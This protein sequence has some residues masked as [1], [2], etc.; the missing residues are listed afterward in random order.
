V[1]ERRNQSVVSMARCML[2][3]K[4]LPGYFW[5]E[6]VT[7]AVHILN[8]APT[9]GL[10]GKTPFEAWHGEK[11]PVHYFKTFGC[12]GNVKNTRPG[13]Q[14]LEDRSCPMIFIGYEHGSKAYHFY[15]PNTECVVVSRDAVFDEGGAWKWPEQHG[16]DASPQDSNTF[17]IEFTEEYQPTSP[18]T[19]H[20]STTP[21]TSS[22]ASVPMSGE[23]AAPGTSDK[24][25]SPLSEH[26]LDLDNDHDDDAPLRFR[27]I[28]S[29]IPAGSTTPRSVPR[30]LDNQLH[31]TSAEEPTTF[32]AAEREPCWKAAMTEEM[33]SITDNATW[34]LAD[35]SPGFRAI[36]LK[37]VYKVKRDEH[38]NIVRYK[39]RLV[40]KGYV[41]CAGVDYDEVFAPVARLES[42]RLMLAVAAH[43]SWRSTTWT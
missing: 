39:A 40:A 15:N 18:A 33:K 22:P 42:V 31:F 38:R 28:D 37:W 5:G 19:E 6:A 36:G 8:R 26:E 13:L 24:F 29:V 32:A 16:V 35:L 21:H 34:E 2:K 11:P 3:A 43:H 4:N 41:Q 25:V 7:T 23:P 20:R 1:V 30:I 14:K 12:I 9:R 10:D 17:T 27:A